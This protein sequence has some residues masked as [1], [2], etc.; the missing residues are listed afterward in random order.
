MNSSHNV[1]Y[2]RRLL[3]IYLV[4]ACVLL[5]I[6]TLASGQDAKVSNEKRVQL[7]NTVSRFMAA[8]SVPGVSVAV[9]ENGQYA[10]SA[11]FGMADLENSVPATAQTLYRLASISKLFTWISVMQ[12]V[13][14]G[15][16]NLDTDVNQ[17]LD[18]H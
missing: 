9:V 14:Q 4:L 15:K 3:C 11:G 18:F 13:E 6:V 12:L 1:T 7:E 2:P 10:W 5:L 8:T 17:Y 16:L